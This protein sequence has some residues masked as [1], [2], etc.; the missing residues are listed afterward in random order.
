MQLMRALLAV[1][2]TFRLTD[3]AQTL[4]S[5]PTATACK[6]PTRLA[7]NHLFEPDRNRATAVEA[8]Q[9]LSRSCVW[10]AL[11]W[12]TEYAN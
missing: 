3:D 7:K 5:P 8:V 4:P 1:S 2:G 10:C 11:H 12:T 9:G 6:W